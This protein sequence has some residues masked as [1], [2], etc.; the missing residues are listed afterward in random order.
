MYC[1][2]CNLNVFKNCF[3]VFKHLHLSGL[4]S[5][6]SHWPALT[7]SFQWSPGVCYRPS[8]RSSPTSSAW[9]AN[10]PSSGRTRRPSSWRRGG[11]RS[12][13][14]WGRSPAGRRRTP[15]LGI[16]ATRHRKT[17]CWTCRG[18]LVVSGLRV[19]RIFIF[20]FFSGLSLLKTFLA[21]RLSGLWIR[22]QTRAAVKW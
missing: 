20:N 12:N 5:T 9:A 15:L 10:I 16:K 21:F 3:A 6:C 7:S 19:R 8:K 13:R 22:G 18:E 11:A 1:S 2:N 14:S 17:C 4:S